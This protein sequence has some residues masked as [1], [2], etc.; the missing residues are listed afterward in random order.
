[1]PH[2]RFYPN[3]EFKE[4]EINASLQ[5]K[6]AIS[7]RGRLISFTDEIENGRILKG[8][9][10]DGYPTFRF[11]VKKD[12]KIINKYLFL[13]KLVAQYFLPKQSEEQT[14]VL[15]LDYNRSNDDISN[16]RWAT[17]QEMMAHSRKSP[18]VI[19]AK[20]NL[21]EHNL[22]ADGR[23]LTTTKVMLIKKILARPE[24]KTRLKMIAKQ[25]GVSE[26]QIR[27][28]ASGENWGHVKV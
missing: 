10:S 18:R 22:K 17:K 21:I 19:Q 8:G 23:K 1:M 6:Y 26:M 14:Y 15:H 27:R 7:N 13:Y 11:K 16:L 5:L 25:F 20:K 12:D 3:E 28:I 9:L 4:I 24:Q 2:N